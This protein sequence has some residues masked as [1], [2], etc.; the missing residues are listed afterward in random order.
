MNYTIVL[1]KNPQVTTSHFEGRT[2]E[3]C[4]E[5]AKQ[6]QKKTQKVLPK[7]TRLHR[8]KK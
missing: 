5:A 2:K 1:D 4:R 6:M 8:H 3:Q 7:I